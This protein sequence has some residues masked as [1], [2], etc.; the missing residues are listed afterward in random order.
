MSL[1]LCWCCGLACSSMQNRSFGDEQVFTG[2]VSARMLS[3]DDIDRHRAYE[4]FFK[5][6]RA[7][8]CIKIAL[9]AKVQGQGIAAKQKSLRLFF[10]VDRIISMAPYGKAES[11][12]TS[13]ELARNYTRSW[14]H[15]R[16]IIL[17]SRKNEPLA[18]IEPGALYR[19]RFTAFLSEPFEYSLTMKTDAAVT[20]FTRDS[21]P[22]EEQ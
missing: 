6:G 14:E 16:E 2:M 1:L 18:R 12:Y 11:R 15:E 8:E 21:L 19:I 3:S 20:V 5:T 17:C 4:L 9:T 10:I 22:R 13:S 7:V